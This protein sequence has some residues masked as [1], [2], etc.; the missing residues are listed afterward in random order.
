MAGMTE[1]VR[2]GELQ[3]DSGLNDFVDNEVLPGTGVAAETFWAGLDAIV[4]DLAPRNARCSRS[5]TGC[6][7]RSTPGIAAPGQAA[8]PGAPTRRS[9]GDRL[10]ASRGPADFASTT[11][12]VDPEIAEHRRAAA[13]GAGDQCP[14]RAERGQRPLGQPLRRALRHRRDPRGRR[15]RSAAAATTRRAAT[16]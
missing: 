3:V 5:A 9:C 10:P 16:R 13:G 1:R 8:R 6:R 11:A 7:P 14:L 15:R 12:N 2:V 4:H